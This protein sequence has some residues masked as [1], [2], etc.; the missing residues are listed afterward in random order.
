MYDIIIAGGGPAGLTA[1]LY[2]LRAKKKV[3]IIEKSA[4]GGQ[5]TSSPKIENYPGYESLSGLDL[6]DK[7]LEQVLS[8]GADIE[9]AEVVEVKDGSVKTVVTDYGEYQSKAVIIATGVVHRHLGLDREEEFVGRGVYYC[10]VCDGGNFNG[11]EVILVGGGNSALQEA[12]LL[13]DICHKVTIV[14]NLDDF[15]GEAA[16]AA[17]VKSKPNISCIF[18]SVVT[19]I[20][21]N[22]EFEGVVIKNTKTGE[23]SK[24][25]ADGM[26]IAIGLI[27]KNKAFENVAPLDKWGYF[28]INESCVSPVPGIFVAGDC[29]SKGIRQ[30]TTAVADGS[31]AALAACDYIDRL[32]V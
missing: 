9:L 23:E 13:S 1:A 25:K 31:C 5:M 26:F 21:G 14:Q 27:P 12:V 18:S 15:T 20:I 32:S 16:M 29:R 8:K 11:R 4:F 10:A 7:M 24:I 17:I 22:K 19:E 6:S 30:I 2:A 28:D 3:L